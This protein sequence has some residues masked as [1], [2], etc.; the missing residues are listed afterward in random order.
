MGSNPQQLATRQVLQYKSSNLTA[1]MS[2]QLMLSTQLPTAKQDEVEAA[3][4]IV[5][6]IQTAIV[7]LFRR[8]D[9]FVT[10][11]TYDLLPDHLVRFKPIFEIFNQIQ[12]IYVVPHGGVLDFRD[13]F[14]W[15]DVLAATN[16]SSTSSDDHLLFDLL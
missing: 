3:V 5:H 8:R 15:F 16:E 9:K 6:E 7:N 14:C 10:P 2:V 11:K 4:M 1:T 13:R 12:F